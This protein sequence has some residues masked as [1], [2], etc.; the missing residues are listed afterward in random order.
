LISQQHRWLL[1]GGSCPS[2][3]SGLVSEFR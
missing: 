1:I 2:S 3:C